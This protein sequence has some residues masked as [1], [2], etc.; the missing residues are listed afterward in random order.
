[1]DKVGNHIFWYLLGIEGCLFLEYFITSSFSVIEAVC[2]VSACLFLFLIAQIGVVQ[3][4]KWSITKK[5][6]IFIYI[7]VRIFLIIYFVI[8]SSI[9][10]SVVSMFFYE[11]FIRHGIYLKSIL[12]IVVILLIVLKFINC[13]LWMNYKIWYWATQTGLDYKRYTLKFWIYKIWTL[14]K[15]LCKIVR[16]KISGK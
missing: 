9:E 15:N 1:M 13:M 4:L 7:Y 16:I 2:V 14:L 11:D 8:V 12:F 10:V 6:S 5:S 3:N